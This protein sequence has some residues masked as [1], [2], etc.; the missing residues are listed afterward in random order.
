LREHDRERE[1]RADAAFE[2]SLPGDY[3]AFVY[4]FEGTVEV[5]AGGRARTL[6]SGH[7]GVLSEG[8]EILV[9]GGAHGGRAL[10][11]AG[12]PIR[13]PV[14][15]YGPFVM[16]TREEVERAVRDYRNGTLTDPGTGSTHAP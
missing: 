13:E 12:R 4:P 1:L 10:L 3:A 15:Q 14:F 11:I 2:H 6:A 9:R 5:V 16:N 7:A 8:E